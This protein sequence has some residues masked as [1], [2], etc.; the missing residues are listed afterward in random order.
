MQAVVAPRAPR[1][2]EGENTAVNSELR[3]ARAERRLNKHE[4]MRRDPAL[5][6]DEAARK[7]R[8]RQ[9]AAKQEM[10]AEN[11]NALDAQRLSDVDTL[12]ECLPR[13]TSR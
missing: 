12:R 13:A 2:P 9:R 5:V 7:A 1:M 4:Q 11:R 8:L 10:H 6:K 3:K